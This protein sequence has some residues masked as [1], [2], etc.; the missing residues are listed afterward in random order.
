PDLPAAGDL[1]LLCTDESLLKGSPIVIQWYPASA[2]GQDGVMEIVNIDF[3]TTMVL[4]PQQ[5]Q[6]TRASLTV[7]KRHL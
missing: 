7:G 3:L 6:I 1:L 2:D 4:E 5:P